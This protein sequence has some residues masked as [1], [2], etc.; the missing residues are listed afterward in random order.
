LL[1]GCAGG[2]GTKTEAIEVGW[3]QPSIFDKPELHPFK[4]RYDTVGLDQDLVS[5]I[6][7]VSS[8]VDFLVFFGTWCG[9]SRRE[10]PHFLKITDRCGIPPS[11]I[12]LYGLDRS[13]KS[14]DGLA[15]RYHI[16]RVPTFIFLRNGSEAGRITE[17]PNATLE[18]DMLSILA[19]VQQK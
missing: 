6:Q 4:A 17:K 8:E 14:D 2:G 11:R 3:L 12:R 10:L 15:D 1:S 13:K 19:S 5:L 9:D 18:A 16:E 7:Q